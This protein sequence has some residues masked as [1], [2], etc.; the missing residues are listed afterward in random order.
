[1]KLSKAFSI[2]MA[3]GTLDEWCIAKVT[4]SEYNENES[5]SMNVIDKQVV[6]RSRA[7]T[8]PLEDLKMKRFLQGKSGKPC[9]IF[10]LIRI[11]STSVSVDVLTGFFLMK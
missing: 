3:F 4:S 9:N 10:S 6:I 7:A 8:I 5:S 2:I 1:M 11:N